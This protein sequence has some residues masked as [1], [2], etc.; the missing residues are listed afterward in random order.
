MAKRLSWTT[1]DFG[2]GRLKRNLLE[3]IWLTTMTA[4]ACELEMFSPQNA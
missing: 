1:F 3:L 2:P 4:V